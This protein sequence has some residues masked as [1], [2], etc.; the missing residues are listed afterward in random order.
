MTYR[1]GKAVSVLNCRSDTEL[2]SAEW[3]SIEPG[4]QPASE[5]ADEHANEPVGQTGWMA[6][7]LGDRVGVSIQR[8]ATGQGQAEVK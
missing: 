6:R 4:I 1:W 7:T 3:I 2:Q 8:T 5:A